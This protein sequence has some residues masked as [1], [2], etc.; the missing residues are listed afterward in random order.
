M[1]CKNNCEYGIVR[2]GLFYKFIL[3]SEK[4]V[5]GLVEMLESPV[6]R[7]RRHAILD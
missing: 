6:D 3:I 2:S 4:T 5:T 7:K 1:Y